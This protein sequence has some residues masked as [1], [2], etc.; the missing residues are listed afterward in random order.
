MRV[1]DRWIGLLGEAPSPVWGARHVW[2]RRGRSGCPCCRRPPPRS[3]THG[4]R[5]GR[6]RHR[7]STPSSGRS[8]AASSF[9]CPPTRERLHRFRGHDDGR[10]C[11]PSSVRDCARAPAT[12]GGD[13]LVAPRRPAPRPRPRW[14]DRRPRP[15]AR[16]TVRGLLGGG[17]GLVGLDHAV[18]VGIR[19]A[20]QENVMAASR[21]RRASASS[22]GSSAARAAARARA[23]APSRPGSACR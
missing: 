10:T 12:L 17:L 11:R 6:H 14:P 19:V 20:G 4:H 15:S 1:D 18:G 22:G 5:P 21:S 9:A 3:T 7:P 13:F 8:G 16:R 2:G 23:S